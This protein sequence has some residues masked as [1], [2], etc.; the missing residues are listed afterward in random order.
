M[1][2]EKF[3]SL[4]YEN[5]SGQFQKFL[6]IYVKT[7]VIYLGAVGLLLKFSLDAS[8]TPELKFFLSSFGIFVCI[9][10]FF[11]ILLAE[12]M[13]RKLRRKRKNTL[14]KLGFTTEEEF[15][16]GHWA[17]ILFSIFNIFVLIGWIYIINNN[18]YLKGI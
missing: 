1:D 4:E 11:C 7:F 13:V 15:V 8:S 12:I 17:S 10:L 14:L 6:E 5:V 16:A 18:F 2:E 3:W 9:L